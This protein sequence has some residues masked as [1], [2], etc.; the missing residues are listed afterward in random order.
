MR[1]HVSLVLVHPH[2][3]I[4][5]FIF[6]LV[7]VGSGFSLTGKCY[8]NTMKGRNIGDHLGRKTIRV[9][10]VTFGFPGGF[11]TIQGT[12]QTKLSSWTLSPWCNLALLLLISACLLSH[13]VMSD[14]L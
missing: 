13:S 4:P 2:L 1:T 6:S 3:L 7:D 10:V 9:A 11:V 12:R 5:V 14:S 8:F